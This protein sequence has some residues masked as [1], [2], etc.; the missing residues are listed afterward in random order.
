[1]KRMWPFIFIAVGIAL[2]IYGI[3]LVRDARACGSW[4]SVD[5]RIVTSEPQVVS[6]QKDQ[7][8]YAPN[9][10]YA[11]TVAGQNYEGSRLTMVPRNYNQ[12]S[13]VQAVLAQYP[14]GGAVKVFHDPQDPA[15][16]VL[17]NRAVGTE[18]A[19]PLAGMIFVVVGVLMF[20]RPAE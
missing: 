5:G 7:R 20:R 14:A 17:V 18:W 12:L 3:G 16:C 1:M 8:T 11:Y 13:A 19:Y 4:P 15:N 10:S 9:V 2:L 6:R